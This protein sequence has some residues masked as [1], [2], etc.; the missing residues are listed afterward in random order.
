MNITCSVSS[1]WCHGTCLPGSYCTRQ[2]STCSPPIAWRCTPSTNSHESRP[3]Q[4]RNGLASAIDVEETGAVVRRQRSHR[5]VF[6]EDHA[7]SVAPRLRPF[8]NRSEHALGRRGHLRHPH[9][10]GVV[11]RIR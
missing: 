5:N 8:L 1:C 7:L 10:D 4:V 3:L 9:A 6:V 11:D 2:S